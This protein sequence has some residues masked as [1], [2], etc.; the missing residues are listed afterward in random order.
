MVLGPGP[1]GPVWA[2][3]GRSRRARPAKGVLGAVGAKGAAAI[4]GGA[5]IAA[6][7]GGAA[8]YVASADG[9]PAP[10]PKPVSIVLQAYSEPQSPLPGGGVWR[11]QGRFVTVKDARSPAVG[12][13]I[14][15]ALRAPLGARFA[16]ARR[17]LGGQPGDFTGLVTAT[18]L[19]RGPKLLSV[20]YDT[21]VRGQV[22]VGWFQPRSVLVDLTTGRSYRPI[23]LFL[24]A[25]VPGLEPFNQKVLAHAPGHAFCPGETTGSGI[26]PTLLTDGSV[27]VMPTP[28][29]VQVTYQGGD[30][31]YSNACGSKRVE[32]PYADIAGL[33]RPE[34][35]KAVPY[36]APSPTRT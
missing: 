32:I 18:V 26:T 17:S 3:R 13:K 21:D 16:Q 14:D 6:G 22:G 8:V 11:T 27:A 5:L 19:L 1:P 35:L 20:R 25:D 24:A 9:K 4:A 28:S 34:I 23:D 2:G 33:I 10:R 36:P 29:G 15:Q 30:L 31:G 12:Q 7:A